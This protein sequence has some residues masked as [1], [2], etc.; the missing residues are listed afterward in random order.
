MIR[1]ESIIQRGIRMTI[2]FDSIPLVVMTD[3]VGINLLL[4]GNALV[5]QVCPVLS[6]VRSKCAVV[7][8][9]MDRGYQYV[10]GQK[11]DI[12]GSILHRFKRVEICQYLYA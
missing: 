1:I 6:R 5:P 11:E 3:Q 7:W 12:A 2:Q 9:I 10:L 4:C 8:R